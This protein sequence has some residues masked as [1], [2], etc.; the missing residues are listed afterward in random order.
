ME[1][2][3][4]QITRQNSAMKT[5][6]NAFG[7]KTETKYPTEIIELPSRGYF[8]DVSNP[9][10]SGEV[11]MKTMTA[12]DEDILTSTS[13]LK[14][15]KA[16]EKLLESLVVSDVDLGTMLLG[17]K[18]ALIFA[19]RRLAY[20]DIYGPLD[21]KCPSCQESNK[22]EVDL[23]KLT[24]K[25]I[26]LDKFNKN[27]NSFPYTLPHS[28]VALEIKL[29]T[30]T[31]EKFIEMELSKLKKE[32]SADVTTRIKYQILSINGDT[33]KAKIKSFVDNQLT[34]KDSLELRRFIKSISPDIDASFDFNC[35]NCNHEERVAVPM[36]VTFFWPD[37]RV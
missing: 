31:D 29:A 8:Y 13:L 17:D 12:K 32:N 7:N 2:E 25:N 21:I 26:D 36:T 34:S 18:N 9:L 24:Y 22:V 4:I 14:K 28:K 33:D 6:I 15:G 3:T 27:I 23:S 20:G 5:V 16:I 37:A 19:A 11:E 30:A 1:D 35:T 10:S